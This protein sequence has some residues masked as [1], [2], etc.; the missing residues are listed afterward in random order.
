[1]ALSTVGLKT[2]IW[3]NNIRILV[4]LLVY[5]PLIFLIYSAAIVAM[6]DVITFSTAGYY[7]LFSKYW[8]AVISLWYIPYAVFT[9]YLLFLYATNYNVLRI[10]AGKTLVTPESNA[11]LYNI[12]EKLCISQGIQHLPYLFIR[13]NEVP[14]AYTSGLSEQTYA[15]VLTSGLLRELE[16]DELEAVLAHELTHIMNKDTRMLFITSTISHVTSQIADMFGLG[17]RNSHS[18]IF[19][20]AAC[21]IKLGNLGALFA[22]AFIS[23]KK[24][25][26]ADAGAVEMTKNPEALISAL[27]KIDTYTT[28][29][30]L[31]QF[32]S[33]LK[34]L[35]IENKET[36]LFATHPPIEDRIKVLEQVMRI[37]TKDINLEMYPF[38]WRA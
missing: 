31:K 13:R 8:G 7:L 3:N 4:F 34:P 6:I 38:P 14:N 19:I 21:F 12:F 33:V 5:P 18:F 36:G 24:E 29:L 25:F 20:I 16:D 10:P 11:K 23:R 28:P 26:I 2:H 32:S 22:Q 27:Q 30:A 9:V 37:D 35:L 17:G 1:M 15:V